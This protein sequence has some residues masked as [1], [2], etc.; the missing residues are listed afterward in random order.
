MNLHFN[1]LSSGSVVHEPNLKQS[2]SRDTKLKEDFI[3]LCLVSEK[4]FS[5]NV[6]YWRQVAREH[7]SPSTLI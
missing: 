3:P 5:L 7:V 6:K 4:L 1:Q 2:C